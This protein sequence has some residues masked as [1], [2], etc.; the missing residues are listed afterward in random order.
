MNPNHTA[1]IVDT[2]K[3]KIQ[4]KYPDASYASYAMSDNYG[5]EP[6][7]RYQMFHDTDA[8]YD[9][10]ELSGFES[11]NLYEGIGYSKDTLYEMFNDWMEK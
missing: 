3:F 11:G 6:D 10:W 7:N 2:K 5:W 8:L 9:Y 1:Y 4:T